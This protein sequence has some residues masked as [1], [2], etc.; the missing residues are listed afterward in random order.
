MQYT[1]S[2]AISTTESLDAFT[3]PIPFW[4][5]LGGFLIHLLPVYIIVVLPDHSVGDYRCAV[6]YRMADADS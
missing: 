5:A 4:Q 3:E 1:V 2:I 6:P